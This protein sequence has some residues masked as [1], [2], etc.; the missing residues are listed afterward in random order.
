MTVQEIIEKNFRDK[1]TIWFDYRD[2]VKAN[3]D[4]YRK[5]LSYRERFRKYEIYIVS[6]SG[7][8]VLFDCLSNDE[9]WKM[10][11]ILTMMMQ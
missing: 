6:E 9:G 11:Y 2:Y 8:E 5:G 10:D 4:V 1:N 3:N 7:D